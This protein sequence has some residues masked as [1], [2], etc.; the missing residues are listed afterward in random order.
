MINKHNTKTIYITCHFLLCF[1]KYNHISCLFKGVS[2]FLIF[3]LQNLSDETLD[4]VN[5]KPKHL[6]Q[7]VSYVLKPIT[8]SGC[9]VYG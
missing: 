6:S 3:R 2:S 9:F 8:W 4:I 1:V 7:M 5:M